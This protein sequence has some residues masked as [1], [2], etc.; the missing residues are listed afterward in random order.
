MLSLTEPTA[1]IDCSGTVEMS[2]RLSSEAPSFRRIFTLSGA[3]CL[4]R[5]PRLPKA[6]PHPFRSSFAVG[7][8]TRQRN[9][10]SQSRFTGYTF[11]AD[12]SQTSRPA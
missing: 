10:L 11:C 7:K 3:T 12:Q 8:G 9:G 4:S 2:S 5:R 6:R 1:A